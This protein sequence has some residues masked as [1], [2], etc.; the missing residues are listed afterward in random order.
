V[1]SSVG[2]SEPLRPSMAGI[3]GPDVAG[4]LELPVFAISAATTRVNVRAPWPW[5]MG[6]ERRTC[7]GYR[8]LRSDSP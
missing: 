3:H 4:E 2:Y 6:P 5:G 8:K 1:Q 7:L